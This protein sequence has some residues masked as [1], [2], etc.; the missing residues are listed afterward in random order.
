M[1]NLKIRKGESLEETNNSGRSGVSLNKDS[2][3]VVSED[4]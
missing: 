1:R 3:H 4:V 2:D